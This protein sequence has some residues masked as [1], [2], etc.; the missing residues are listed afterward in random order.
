MHD[1]QMINRI[2]AVLRFERGICACD[3]R[4]QDKT[5]DADPEPMDEWP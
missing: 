2:D 3:G 1:W 5:A 4:R